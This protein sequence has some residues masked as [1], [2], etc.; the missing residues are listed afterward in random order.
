MK[1]IFYSAFLLGVSAVMFGASVTMAPSTTAALDECAAK[2][3]Q[4]EQASKFQKRRGR[5]FYA[6]ARGTGDTFNGIQG[7][8][9]SSRYKSAAKAKSNA[10]MHCGKSNN[11][12]TCKVI[13]LFRWSPDKNCKILADCR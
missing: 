12:H 5:F 8:G 13:I 3:N 11:N 6:F 10:M 7:C 9:W 2:K 4:Y 1:S